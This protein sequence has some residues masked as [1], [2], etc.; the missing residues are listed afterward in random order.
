MAY[1][2]GNP[3]SMPNYPAYNAAAY[4]YT[5]APQ[6]TPQLQPAQNP[7]NQQNTAT[8]GEP[9]INGG[10]IVLPS[11]EDIK[12]YPVAPGNLVTF[13][14]ENKPVI[15]EKSMGRSPFDAPHYERYK[16]IREE[17]EE[18]K[19]EPAKSE[20]DE[21]EAIKN[22]LE[23]LKGNYKELKESFSEIEKLMKTSPKKKPRE[24]EEIEEDAV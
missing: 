8:Q 1:N 2:F 9:L 13:K 15:I 4:P 6:I 14:I 7:Q 19:P 11:E 23:T 10:F 18:E 12:R 21:L 16:L 20:P 3:Y 24:K 22:E 5:G 17:M